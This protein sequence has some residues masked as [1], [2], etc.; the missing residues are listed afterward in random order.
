LAFTLAAQDT[1]AD[2][3]AGVII[4]LDRLFRVGDRIEIPGSSTWGDVLNIGR[5]LPGF[6]RVTTG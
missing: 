5:V 6:E 2:A 4:L 3:I 1:I